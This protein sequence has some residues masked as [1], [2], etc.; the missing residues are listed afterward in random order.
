MIIAI[1]ARSDSKRFPRKI[2]KKFNKKT[3]LENIIDNLKS[4]DL[5]ICVC[6]TKRK[7]DSKI[8][9]I[10][11]K[12]NCLFFG[13][14]KNNVLR[15]LYECAKKHDADCLIRINGDSPLISAHV[16]KKQFYLEKNLQNKISSPMYFQEHFQKV[17]Q[18]KLLKKMFEK[19]N[20]MN[21]STS[22]KEHVTKY[23][24]ENPKLFKIK[25]FNVIKIFLLLIY[26]L[27]KKDFNF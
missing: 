9:T 22:D 25:I 16:I 13:G 17:C 5:K 1:Q 4:L 2:F 23:I 3:V 26:Q 19:L 8:K 7:I 10:A 27:I 20:S 21:L 11:K 6:S 18:L 15:R 12:K 14:S 24:Y